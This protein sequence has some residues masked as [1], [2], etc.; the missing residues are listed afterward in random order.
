[1]FELFPKEE[2]VGFFRGFTENNGLEFHADLA[3]P[4]QSRF[5]RVPMHGQ[6]I[7]VQLEHEDEAILGRIT[8]LSSE[9]RLTGAAGERFTMRAIRE[10]RQI[11][12]RLREDYLTYRIDIRVLGVLRATP[13][14]LCFVLWRCRL[15]H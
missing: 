12:E 14:D 9:G 8:A 15:P 3:L 10:D 4:Y 11:D 5:N 7:L 2:V 13:S 6:F 1:M